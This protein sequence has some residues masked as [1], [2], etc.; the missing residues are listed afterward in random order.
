MRQLLS[1]VLF[2]GI[3]HL[4]GFSQTCPDTVKFHLDFETVD[5]ILEVHLSAENFIDVLSFQSSL[6][7]PTQDLYFLGAESAY[8]EPF[9]DANFTNSGVGDI[10]LLWFD[11]TGI[12]PVS[13]DPSETIITF[14][15]LPVNDA[16]VHISLSNDP[17]STEVFYSSGEACYELTEEM[18]TVTE[19]ED[20]CIEFYFENGSSPGTHIDVDL[21]VENFTDIYSIQFTI[22]YDPEVLAFDTMYSETL[23]EFSELN[24]FN[25]DLGYI[26]V[27]YFDPALIAFSLEDGESLLHLS[28]DVIEAQSTQL[29]INNDPLVVE[30][31]NADFEEE[32]MVSGSADIVGEGA[33][34]FGQVYFDENEDCEA[35]D[36]S[37][38]ANWMVKIQGDNFEYVTNT[39]ADGSYGRLLP[40]GSYDVSIIPLNDL[41][42]ECAPIS[43]GFVDIGLNQEINLSA[44][45]AVYCPELHVSLNT[46]FLRRCF[47][48]TYT[49]QYCNNGTQEEPNPY[50]DIILDEYFDFVSTSYDTYTL[51]NDTLQF[52]LDTLGVGECGS[53]SFTVYLQCDETTLGQTHCAQ[54]IIY[55]NYPCLSIIDP[56]WTKASLEIE[57]ICD[58]TEVQFTITNVGEGS[59]AEVQEFIVIEDDVMMP[60]NDNDVDLEAGESI[61]FEWP[62]NGSTYRIS[63]P[64]EPNHPGESMPTIALEACGEN[65]D[66]TFSLGFVTMFPENDLD[67]F[68]DI[69]CQENIGSYDP[70]DKAAEPKGYRE[71]HLIKQNTPIDY[72]IRFQNTGTDTAF[73]ITIVD[74]ISTHL[75]LESFVLKNASHSCNYEVKE[76]RSICFTFADILLVDSTTNEALSHGF[77]RFSVEQNADLPFGTLI[78]NE[79]DIYFDFNEPI[80]TNTVFHEIG[81]DFVEIISSTPKIND[82]NLTLDVYPNPTSQSFF[83]ALDDIE[84][85]QKKLQIFTITGQLINSKVLSQGMNEVNVSHLSTGIYFCKVFTEQG[86]LGTFRIEIL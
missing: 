16:T 23:N 24:Y 12:N 86:L 52:D 34:I 44:K 55:P 68:T 58:E 10:S 2:I 53:M 11:N 76:D 9:G 70:N 82:P 81:D 77:V 72:K 73:N 48:N 84:Q 60:V 1:L 59:M 13:V 47:E 37:T 79:A 61:Q 21:L 6:S 71:Q 40:P 17:T 35:N 41:W 25:P 74:T 30:I 27:S 69:D 22:N 20:G 65:E 38:L 42:V 4:Q 46:P 18:H 33:Y 57:G 7:Y 63:I 83:L 62:A 15:F 19:A 51:S 29:T 67:G 56:S 75:S 8:L 50:I 14:R 54:A 85:R 28:F 43:S 36:A 39:Q 78:L 26:T 49:V 5:E 64:Q 45:P 31:I 66:G 32:C 80:R 3:F